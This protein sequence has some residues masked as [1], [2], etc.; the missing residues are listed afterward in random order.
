M[1]FRCC[2]PAK[3]G[4]ASVSPKKRVGGG[5]LSRTPAPSV[6]GATTGGSAK[7][8]PLADVDCD[9]EVEEEI[10]RA[11]AEGFNL[12]GPGDSPPASPVSEVGAAPPP[13]CQEPPE[14]LKARTLI[15]LDWDDTLLTT[16]R[17]TS[18]HSVFGPGGAFPPHS[19]ASLVRGLPI[20]RFHAPNTPGRLPFPRPVRI[21]RPPC[22]PF[23]VCCPQPPSRYPPRSRGT[24]RCSRKMCCACSLRA[25]NVDGVSSSRTPL[26]A[27]FSR[28]GGVSCPVS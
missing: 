18:R 2:P 21:A 5:G 19:R 13:L 4:A 20:P 27:G 1:R 8:N 7:R 11:F 15:I 17:L 9:D 14:T 25:S 6:R 28:A 16:T 26:R 23:R 22:S 12:E 24:W 10:A 3:P